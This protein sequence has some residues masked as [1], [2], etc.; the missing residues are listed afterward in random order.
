M[1]LRKGGGGASVWS[2]LVVLDEIILHVGPSCLSC[3]YTLTCLNFNLHMSCIH[4]VGSPSKC[5]GNI[6]LP[7]AISVGYLRGSNIQTLPHTWLKTKK[8]FYNIVSM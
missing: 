1:C 5:F 7:R 4:P 2:T 6:P 3:K 8:T